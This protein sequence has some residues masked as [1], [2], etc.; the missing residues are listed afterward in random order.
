MVLPSAKYQALGS[1]GNGPGCGSGL[2][3]GSTILGACGITGV[4]GPR[5]GVAVGLIAGRVGSGTGLSILTALK[6]LMRPLPRNEPVE[7]GLTSSAVLVIN[8]RRSAGV[9]SGLIESSSAASPETCGAAA[10]VPVCRMYGPLPASRQAG[11][12]MSTPGAATA[13]YGWR[14]E[15]AGALSFSSVAPTAITVG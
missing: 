15:N 9:C 14:C 10:D 1:L 3:D 13:T 5:S 12:G 6:A 7:R 4:P 11:P 8:W 2:I